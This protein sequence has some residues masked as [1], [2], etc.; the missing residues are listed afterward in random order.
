MKEVYI[1][2]IN[3]TVNPIGYS[4]LAKAQAYMKAK[5]KEMNTFQ[6]ESPAIDEMHAEYFY[7]PKNDI[8]DPFKMGTIRI[9]KIMVKGS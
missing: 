8:N 1:V 4:D 2:S 5:A 6:G 7:V 3:G 9:Q